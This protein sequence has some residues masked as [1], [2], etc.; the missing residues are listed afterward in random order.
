MATTTL[1]IRPL[2]GVLGAEIHGIDLRER[3]SD[4]TV[5]A[6]RKAL[7]DH[8]VI[9]FRE[10]FIEAAD[11]LRLA[12][13]MGSVG[14]APFGP[15]HPD[16][17]E[18]TVLDQQTPKGEGADE[19]HTDNTYMPNPP[20][21]S[22]LR[23]VVLPSVGGD[24]M[25]ASMYAA[26]E[27]LSTPM[28]AMLGE[29]VAV[30]DLTRMLTKARRNGQ[31]TE[32]IEE[33]Q[34]R[35]PPRRHPV[36]RTNPVTGRKALFVSR[37]WVSHLEGLSERENEALLPFLFDH[38]RDPLFQV[39]FRWAPGSI[40]FWDNR[41]VQHYGVPDYTGERRVM[42]RVTLDGDIPV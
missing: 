33:M 16:F 15:K 6:V 42:H 17:P 3:L 26:Y 34:R 41:W 27:A 12:R 28:Q 36:V 18:I 19:W 21:G 1:D 11:H 13:Q 39:R 35:F 5:A 7:D 20:F 40:A 8:Q 32:G 37:N 4:E 30:H 10:Q 38:A 2:T 22:I 29:M 14:V 25:F 9:F 31:A 24:T 23:C